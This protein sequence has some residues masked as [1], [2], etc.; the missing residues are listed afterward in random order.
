MIRTVI[1]R[2]ANEEMLACPI[3]LVIH[4]EIDQGGEDVDNK[5]V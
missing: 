1:V 3:Q 5:E 4:L 2:D